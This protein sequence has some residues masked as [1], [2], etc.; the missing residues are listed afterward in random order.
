MKEKLSIFSMETWLKMKFWLLVVFL[1]LI[2]VDICHIWQVLI[3]LTKKIEEKLVEKFDFLEKKSMIYKRVYSF[4]RYL[5]VS[6]TYYVPFWS[7][8]HSHFRTVILKIL[9]VSSC[10][11]PA[12]VH[13]PSAQ[14]R[15]DRPCAVAGES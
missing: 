8:K 2:E 7:L 15:A 11:L 6:T 5:R 3:Y 13:S 10:N 12:T 1:A 14:I 4:I 9:K